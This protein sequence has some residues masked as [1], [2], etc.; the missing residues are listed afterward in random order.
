MGTDS[1]LEPPV[2]IRGT[3]SLGFFFSSVQNIYTSLAAVFQ[4][5]KMNTTTNR[6]LK[7]KCTYSS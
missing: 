7:A 4:V 5:H 6:I 3:A 1:L 2:D